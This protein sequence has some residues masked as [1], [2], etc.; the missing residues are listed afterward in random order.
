M[1]PLHSSTDQFLA[2]LT[3]GVLPKIG[4]REDQLR[5]V[6]D[7]DCVNVLQAV[8]DARELIRSGRENVLILAAEKVE[9]ELYRFRKY[10][11]FSD[12]CLALLLERPAPA[13]RLEILDVHIRA[14]SDPGEEPAESWRETWRRRRWRP[15][16]PATAWR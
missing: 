2:A 3:S 5:C 14:D 15:S 12:F 8:A 16:S 7:R 1:R 4:T 6:Y 11:V 13:L 10:S 9:E